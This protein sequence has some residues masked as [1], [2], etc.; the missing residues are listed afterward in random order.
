M[1]TR[2]R[3]FSQGIEP[4][5]ARQSIEIHL[6]SA[7]H[8]VGCWLYGDII[9][10]DVYTH[11]LAFLVYVGEVLASLLGVFMSDIEAHV[12][13]SV[14]LHLL[15]DCP[16]HNVAGCKRQALVVFLHKGLAV[17]Q[18]QYTAIST[19]GLG[20]EKGG[21]CLA[22]VIQCSGM[23]LHK[24]HVCHCSL[25]PI[26][27]CLTVTC[28]YHGV[29]GCLIYC[30]ATACAHHRH[31]TQIGIHLLCLRIQHV[32]SIAVDVGSAACHPSS[33][34]VLG[35]NLHGEMV[36]LDGDVGTVAHCL[37]QSALYLGSCIILVMQDTKLRVTAF[38]MEVELTV[39]LPVEVHTPLHQF[40]YLPWRILH[41]QLHCFGV[42]D[43]VAGYHRV[44]DVLV[45][46]VELQVCHRS[47]S[48]LCE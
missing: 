24:L 41:H 31:L 12:V 15:V 16:C 27:H 9:G 43:I 17:G 11:R 21:M 22:W 47:H 13:E 39:L 34:V 48:T 25:C 33:Q 32:C 14:Y 4:V 26:H 37:H 2:A 45:E 42:A 44:L 23:E 1:Q 5:Y 35:D 29:G 28:G 38:A 3:T 20:D 10:S 36:L 8:I 30:T 7:T 18:F 46:I 19:H 40:T 6:Y